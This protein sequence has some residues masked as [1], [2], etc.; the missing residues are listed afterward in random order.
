VRHISDN[1]ELAIVN[2]FRGTEFTP[3]ALLVLIVETA[4]QVAANVK[5]KRSPTLSTQQ[6]R[7]IYARVVRQVPRLWPDNLW[8]GI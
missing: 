3:E 4:K 6:R 1:V 5:A 7:R 2:A 8:T